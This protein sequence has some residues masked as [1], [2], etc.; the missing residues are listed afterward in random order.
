MNSF[1]NPTQP[2]RTVPRCVEPRDVGQQD[3]C[4][5]DV[6]CRLLATDV[7]FARLQRKSKCGPTCGV[8]ADSD[9]SPGEGARV[10]VAGRD[11][12]GM[13]ATEAH[14]HTESLGQT[15]RDVHPTV[16]GRGEQNAGQEIS[17]SSH[18]CA[19]GVGSVDQTHVIVQFP[20]RARPGN[21][22]AE[23][24]HRVERLTV[25]DHD[26][27]ADRGGPGLQDGDGLRVCVFVDEERRSGMCRQAT[28]HR[29]RLG[30]GRCL[31]EQ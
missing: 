20:A 21:K 19:A 17:G 3:L 1:G 24:G 10:G 13:R 18:Q 31:V 6:R 11:E 29:H 30:G 15:D 14:R 27:D 9:E 26:F 5:A 2:F 12:G 25:A 23:A 22:R 7:L 8:G 28:D 16:A 4:C